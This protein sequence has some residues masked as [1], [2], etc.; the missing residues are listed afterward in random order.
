MEDSQFE[1]VYEGASSSSYYEPVR[2]RK[3][4]S[5]KARL[6]NE[7]RFYRSDNEVDNLLF[8]HLLRYFEISKTRFH[9]INYK[10]SVLNYLNLLSSHGLDQ[11]VYASMPGCE[12]YWR[13]NYNNVPLPNMKKLLLKL[14]EMEDNVGLELWDHAF[15]NIPV[16]TS[17]EALDFVFRAS[18]VNCHQNAVFFE[19]EKDYIS[20]STMLGAIEARK[21]TTYKKYCV[22]PHSPYLPTLFL[23]AMQRNLNLLLPNDLLNTTIATVVNVF[24]SISHGLQDWVRNPS[25]FFELNSFIFKIAN[26]LKDEAFDQGN[27][28]ALSGA[29]RFIGNGYSRI[30]EWLH[31]YNQFV[32]YKDNRTEEQASSLLDVCLFQMESASVDYWSEALILVMVTL[33]LMT[34]L[35]DFDNFS[36]V[37]EVCR[38]APSLFPTVH[39]ILTKRGREDVLNKLIGEVLKGNASELAGY[40][41][42][43]AILHTRAVQPENFGVRDDVISDNIP[44]VFRMLDVGRNRTDL[45]IWRSLYETL[46]RIESQPEK[47]RMDEYNEKDIVLIEHPAVIKN[48]EKGLDTLGGMSEIIDALKGSKTLELRFNPENIY[49]NGIQAE[50]KNMVAGLSGLMQIVFK[51][52]RKK[53]NPDVCETECLGVISNVYTFSSMADFQYL[54]VRTSNKL[55]SEGTLY[56]DLVPRLV[57][58]SLHTAFSWFNHKEPGGQLTP[59]FLPPYIFSRYTTGASTKILSHEAEKP[60]LTGKVSHGQN[61]RTER[62]AY[63]LTLQHNDVFPDA[64][65]EQAIADV[66]SRV[67]N[68]EPHRL[69]KELFEE[70]PMWNRVAIQCRTKLDDGILKVLMAKYAFYIYS[71]PWGRLWCKFGY[72]PRTTP[73]AR[74]YQTVVVSFR[75]HTKIPERH[76]RLRVSYTDSKVPLRMDEDFIYTPGHLP[77]VRQMWYSICD[78]HLPVAQK[79]V[80][81]DY[82]SA[83]DHYDPMTGWVT[84]ETIKNIRQSIKEDVRRTSK[85]LELADPETGDA[86]LSDGSDNSE[87]NDM[88]NEDGTLVE[89][90][91]W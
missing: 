1:P 24:K 78:I 85:Q 39:R 88:M 37:I 16:L 32:R 54:P 3:K 49:Q 50:K 55:S 44:A 77:A 62:K 66:E 81:N 52:R 20:L 12:A 5:V 89:I 80:Q 8:D 2:K 72:D 87:M 21:I 9:G 64:P 74:K 19:C 13:K 68:P 26:G 48:S 53:S 11:N 28:I 18:I 4:R 73:E 43:K 75:K 22:R 30:H 61:L 60:E 34:D 76:K 7:F 41:E 79:V 27:A 71:G 51:I 69:L 59:R 65:S 56:E 90:A 29:F 42:L 25:A 45:T 36:R 40:S 10:K 15:F 33:E 38:Y 31:L 6:K 57:P 46:R 86:N 14:G 23:C 91:E 84:P 67:K 35:D 70:R 17:D 83:L 63:T 58:T 82:C 47:F